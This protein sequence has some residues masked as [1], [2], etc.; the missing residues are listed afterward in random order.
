LT[1][2]LGRIA[3]PGARHCGIAKYCSRRVHMI[4]NP[5]FLA[6]RNETARACERVLSGAT[7]RRPLAGNLSRQAIFKGRSDPHENIFQHR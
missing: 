1:V 4:V 7:S 6:A 3:V 2:S 5:R